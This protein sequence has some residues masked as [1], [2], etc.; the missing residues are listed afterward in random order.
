MRG[1]QDHRIAEL[2]L[3][4]SNANRLIGEAADEA[5]RLQDR[6]D[7]TETTPRASDFAVLEKRILDI[8]RAWRKADIDPNTQ[9]GGTLLADLADAVDELQ[10][11][12]ERS[13]T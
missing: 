12:V 11:A 9:P 5:Q 7:L 8:A 13:Q 2:E 1:N 6:I 4:L 3:L 10:D